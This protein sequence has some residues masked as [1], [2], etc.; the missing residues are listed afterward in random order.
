MSTALQVA[1]TYAKSFVYVALGLLLASLAVEYGALDIIASA[2]RRVTDRLGLDPEAASVIPL[3]L[4]SPSAAH[5]LLAGLLEE[6]RVS[7]ESVVAAVLLAAPFTYVYHLIRWHIPV[8][9][10]LLGLSVGLAYI[11]FSAVP[12]TVKA[13]LGVLYAKRNRRKH[14][15]ASAE[16]FKA[17]RD[18]RRALRSWARTMKIVTPRYAVAAVVAVALVAADVPKILAAAMRPVLSVLGLSA[19]TIMVVAA[20]MAGPTIGVVVCSGLLASMKELEAVAA[21]L[22]GGAMYLVFNEIPRRTLPFLTGIY[23]VKR[24]IRLAALVVGI[25][26]L[27]DLALALTLL[28]LS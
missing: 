8:V 9:L 23:G 28:F 10:P 6:K 18:P 4:A 14:G 21:L 13:L 24:G 7:W 16:A 19:S 22:L 17:S 2:L 15:K 25:T 5:G 26:V 27:V 1:I 12:S 3:F 11:A 20:T